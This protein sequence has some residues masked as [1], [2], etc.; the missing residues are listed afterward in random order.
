VALGNA[1][2]L[3]IGY[4]LLRK[5]RLTAIAALGT[6]VLLDLIAS[7]AE[8]WYEILLL[9][10]WAAGMAHGWFLARA[11]RSRSYGAGSARGRSPSRSRWY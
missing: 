1:S 7:T 10:W 11:A 8:T 4:L 9:L 2:L 3:G 5:W 6:A